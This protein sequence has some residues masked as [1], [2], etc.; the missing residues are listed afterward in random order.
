MAMKIF[1]TTP[2]AMYVISNSENVDIKPEGL[3]LCV[4]EI[5]DLIEPSGTFTLTLSEND[6]LLI[7]ENQLYTLR[8]EFGATKWSVNRATHITPFFVNSVRREFGI[9]KYE[10]T[11]V[12]KSFLEMTG[13]YSGELL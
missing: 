8:D 3:E 7:L 1:K 13:L 2:A 9:V 4:A 10:C 12:Y 5:D 6:P 11:K